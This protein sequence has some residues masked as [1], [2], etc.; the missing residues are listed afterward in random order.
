MKFT[1]TDMQEIELLHRLCENG[2]LKPFWPNSVVV[3]NMKLNK[4]GGVEFGTPLLISEGYISC[5]ENN[6]LW[7]YVKLGYTASNWAQVLDKCVEC[8][9]FHLTNNGF[10]WHAVL[11]FWKSAVFIAAVC[12]Y[13]GINLTQKVKLS[14]SYNNSKC[15]Q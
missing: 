4:A 6:T 9:D 5:Y 8:N 10:V 13:W 3:W 1:Y 7:M 12:W 2:C 11:P 14:L 15:L